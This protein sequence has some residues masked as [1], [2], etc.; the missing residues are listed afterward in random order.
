MEGNH[1]EAIPPAAAVPLLL[2]QVRD[3][4]LRKHYSARIEQ[5]YVHWI[6]RFIY[7]S[8]KRHPNGL[9]GA[10]DVAYLKHVSGELL[11]SQSAKSSKSDYAAG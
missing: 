9:C 11:S 7:F 2:D 1:T 10:E 6:K 4:I 3:A 8:G 5:A